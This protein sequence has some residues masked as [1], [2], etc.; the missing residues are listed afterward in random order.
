M[1]AKIGGVPWS[2][3]DLPYFNIPTM[4]VGYDVHHKRG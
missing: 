4:L 3:G 2:V 1:N